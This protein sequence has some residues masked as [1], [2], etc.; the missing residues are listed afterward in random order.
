MAESAKKDFKSSHFIFTIGFL[1]I[2]YFFASFGDLLA[3]KTVMVLGISLM[4]IAGFNATVDIWK[5]NK[6]KG[7]LTPF[8]IMVAIVALVKW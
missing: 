3:L 4:I 5:R 1:V 2:G 6:I 7:I 8:L